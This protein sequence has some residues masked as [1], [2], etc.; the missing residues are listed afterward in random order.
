M[1]RLAKLAQ[2]SAKEVCKILGSQGFIPVRQ[3]GSHIV[4][5]KRALGSTT[6]AI[7]PSHGNRSLAIGTLSGIIDQASLPRHLFDVGA[8]QIRRDNA[9]SL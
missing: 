9:L 7:V 8:R 5:Q 3:S 1:S 2:L 4:M 6:T